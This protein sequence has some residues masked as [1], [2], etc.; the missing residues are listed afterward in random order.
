[1]ASIFTRKAISAILT[2]E[3]LTADEKNERIFGLYGQALDDGYVSKASAAS[4]QAAAIEA[5]KAEAISAIEKPDPTQSEQYKTLAGEFEAFKTRTA[6]RGSEE[7]AGIKPKF[8]DQVYDMIDRKDGAKPVKEQLAAIK[9]QY[10]EYFGESQGDNQSPKN[11][12]QYSK[13]PGR[14]GTNPTSDED[15]LFQ[16]LSEA[17]R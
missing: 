4:A 3:A 8:F 7:Y 16:Q 6:A 9:E 14:T 12:P 11:T 5:A 10:E 1:M 15:K 2:D 17:W 13:A